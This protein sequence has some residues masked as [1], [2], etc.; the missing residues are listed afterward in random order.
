VG[1]GNSAL[2]EAQRAG[3]RVAEYER[4]L[5][6]ERARVEAFRIA[7]RTEAEVGA[8]L[9]A[10]S[11]WGWHLLPDRR[12]PGTRSANIDL[13]HVG[14]G[15][16]LV[17]DVKSW[18]EPDIVDGRLYRGQW[19][20]EDEVDKLRRVSELVSDATAE[21][22]LAPTE[23]V[24]VMVFMNQS[25][26]DTAIGRIKIVDEK[27]L[28]PWIIRRGN[29]LTEPQV[30]SLVDLLEQRFPPCD[31]VAHDAPV[32]VAI[33]DPVLP[34]ARHSR[35]EPDTLFDAA[36]LEESLLQQA[37]LAPIE[38]WM[39][40]LHPEQLRVVRR[41]ATGPARIRGAA[42]TGK[43]VLA[44][45]R[46]AY[47]AEA[48]RRPVLVTSFIKTLPPVL[49]ELYQR[50][51][52]HTVDR[53]EFTNLHAWASRLLKNRGHSVR[54][55]PYQA[56]TAFARA[57]TKYGKNSSLAE[58][59]VPREYWRD[60][61]D[62]VI[63]G[64][65]IT[66]YADYA[67]LARIGRRTRLG[68]AQR[69]T[70]W[71]IYTEY[72]AQLREACL[73]DFTDLLSLAIIELREH[74]LGSGYAAVIV[75]EVQDLNCQAIRLLAEISSAGEHL[76]LIGDGQQQ[77]YPGG[78]TLAEG[79]ISV[80]GRS[81]VLRTNYRNAADI[82]EAA[83]RVVAE[84][85]YNDLE[86]TEEAGRRDVVAIRERG[87]VWNVAAASVEWLNQRAVQHVAELLAT[88]HDPG[89]IAILCGTNKEIDEHQKWLSRAGI[90]SIKLAAYAGVPVAAVKV[91]T[92]ARAKGLE[93]KDVVV[94][95]RGRTTIK[96]ASGELQQEERERDNRQ[97]FV[98]MTRARDTLW[99]GRLA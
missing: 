74:P 23:V 19:D 14:P 6:A 89:G 99:I 80:A 56:N 3:L 37:L 42:G 84:D 28:V 70:V 49:S 77:I 27:S 25:G 67:D 8:R 47:L 34:L 51:S 4:R 5:L 93:F 57:W 69:E 45:H 55:D 40:F 21:L 72:E 33:P 98:A 13:I 75:D 16:V 30:D 10:M 65:G 11:G 88:G 48:T 61:I 18:A 64:R 31:L 38:E 43:T 29:R 59:G 62:Y 94:T 22:G 17:I 86:G 58:V 50:L 35:V 52:P 79:G 71:E 53:V 26:T 82:V 95:I 66:D 9:A 96:N 78:Y 2:R 83:A 91:G 36:A 85:G 20:A 1:A 54:V 73:T 12:W 68:S 92:Y 44:L 97:L 60:E 81:A 76:L 24:P 63:K 39:T 7:G 46:A 87:Q 90:P 32:S 41:L 15:G